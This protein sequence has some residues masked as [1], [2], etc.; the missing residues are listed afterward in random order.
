MSNKKKQ[1]SR[2]I[3]RKYC[4]D[5]TCADILYKLVIL[6]LDKKRFCK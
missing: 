6:Y 3:V 4:V 1:A 5:K 2:K